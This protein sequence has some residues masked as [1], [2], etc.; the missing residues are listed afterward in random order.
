MSKPLYD[1]SQCDIYCIQEKEST[2]HV[3]VRTKDGAFIGSTQLNRTEGNVFVPDGI[4]ARYSYGRSLHR[5]LIDI[6]TDLGGSLAIVR[7]GDA[8]GGA[9]TV[10]S[11]F[12]ADK[13]L[14]KR[15]IKAYSN[16]I[17]WTSIDDDPELFHSFQSGVQRLASKDSINYLTEFNDF[18]RSLHATGSRIFRQ[19]YD[20]DSNLWIED[21]W[22][23]KDPVPL[24]FC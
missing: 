2:F 4:V 9:L 16:D 11:E 15:N 17:D 22:P 10:W 12:Y 6:A 5:L 1:L 20:I 19:S 7:D 3:E 18:T 14:T 24:F 8:R 13:T 21:E 23:L